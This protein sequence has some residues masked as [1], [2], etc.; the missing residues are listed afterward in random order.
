MKIY[1]INLFNN[2][3]FLEYI[4]LFLDFNFIEKN[5]IINYLKVDKILNN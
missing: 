4:K 5:N 1:L 3:K 2:N